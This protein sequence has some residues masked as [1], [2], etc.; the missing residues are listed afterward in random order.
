MRVKPLRVGKCLPDVGKRGLDG[1]SA[2]VQGAA[3][4][5]AGGRF[6]H[7]VVR[8]ETHERFN[9]MAVPGIGE[10]LQVCNG[11]IHASAPMWRDL[12]IVAQ[13]SRPRYWK[14]QTHK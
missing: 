10:G 2:D 8:H 4:V 3:D 9:I 13:V 6:E 1:F 12:K 11:D 14:A 5:G 7:T